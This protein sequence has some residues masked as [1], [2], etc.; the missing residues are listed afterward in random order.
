MFG[1]RREAV[2]WMLAGGSVVL[3]ACGNSTARMSEQ[4]DVDLRYPWYD[5][6]NV[7][8]ARRGPVPTHLGDAYVRAPALSPDGSLLA[9]PLPSFPV[10]QLAVVRLNDGVGWILAHQ[11]FR[12]KLSHPAF[13]PDGKKLALI[14]TPPT[15]YGM[16]EIWVGGVDG[17][18][19]SVVSPPGCFLLPAFSPDS[20]RLVCFGVLDSESIAPRAYQFRSYRTGLL[21]FSLWEIDLQTRATSQIADQAWTWVNRVSYSNTRA[22]LFLN[23]G[24]PSRRALTSDGREVWERGDVSPPGFEGFFLS[25]GQEVPARPDSIGPL[26]ASGERGA[27]KGNDG[28]DNLLFLVSQQNTASPY[29]VSSGA[30]LWNGSR[31]TRALSPREA[32]LQECTISWDGSTI[33]G[34]AHSLFSHGQEMPASPVDRIFFVSRLG[35]DQQQWSVADL[36]LDPVQRVVRPM[37]SS[38]LDR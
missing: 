29:G 33:V 4:G 3:D 26:D 12:V 22:G 30:V 14:A 6:A 37:G 9:A 2:K 20:Q 19:F 24:V 36:E 28:E 27:F 21:H 17:G 23:T 7:A 34:V 10:N 31:V 11:N 38:E 5:P 16:S 8:M 25:R 32:T 13:S 35:Q 1:N 18:D 15:Y